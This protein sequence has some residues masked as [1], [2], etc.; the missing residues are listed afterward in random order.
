MRASDEERRR[1]GELLARAMAEGRLTVAEFEERTDQ[2]LAA[3]TRGEL[4]AVVTDLPAAPDAPEAREVVELGDGTFADLHRSGHWVVP[5]SVR[6]AGRFGDVLLDFSEAELTSDVTTVELALGTG[7]AT[8]VVPT[9]ATVDA[10]GVHAGLGDV[11]DRTVERPG[12]AA[13][14]F[15]IRGSTGA[16]DV[17]I[18]HPTTYRIGKLLVRRYPFRLRWA[19]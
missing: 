6:V 7:D 1:T 11:T 3:R 15:V 17:R 16:G 12:P 4:D 2:A 5:P 18:V 9:G 13:H 10:D 14:R 8:I 19:R